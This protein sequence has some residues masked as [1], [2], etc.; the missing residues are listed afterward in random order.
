MAYVPKFRH[1]FKILLRLRD[2]QAAEGLW[3]EGTWLH[4]AGD[5]EGALLAFHHSRLLD[6]RFGGAYY[7][8]AALTE[9]LH[10]PSPRAVRAWRDYLAV[11][12]GDPRQHPDT[13]AKVRHHVEALTREGGDR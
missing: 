8:Y 2:P 12:E 13:I 1:L 7:N 5:D 11:A 10:G 4:D 3:L 6:R 9:K